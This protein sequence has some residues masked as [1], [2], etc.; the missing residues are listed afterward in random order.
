[1]NFQFWHENRDVFKGGRL[2]FPERTLVFL[3][4]L[5]ENRLWIGTI[6]ARM[7]PAEIRIYGKN[8][9]FFPSPFIIILFSKISIKRTLE[10]E[11]R[12]V[13]IL[14]TEHFFPQHLTPSG[15]IAETDQPELLLSLPCLPACLPALTAWYFSSMNRHS[16]ELRAGWSERKIFIYDRLFSGLSHAYTRVRTNRLTY[17]SS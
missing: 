14:K 8:P 15:I 1:M 11:D 7:W 17:L 12:R 2:P 6:W 4:I 16:W 10:E 13:A 9:H 5:A 3:K